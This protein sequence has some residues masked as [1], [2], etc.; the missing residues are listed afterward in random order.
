MGVKFKDYY[1]VLGVSRTASDEEI[2]KSFRKLARQHHPDVAKDKKRAEEKFKEINEAYEVLGDPAKRKKYDELG[3]NWKQGAEFRPP[4]G[5]EEMFQRGAS[6]GAGRGRGG[7]HEFQF[8][9]SGFSDFFE[10]FFA[11]RGRDGGRFRRQTDVDEEEDF[12]ERGAD[13]EGEILVTLEESLR[14]S[15][16]NVSVRTNQE[17]E[18]CGGTGGSR[19][20][21][22]PACGG[23]GQVAATETHKVKIPPGVMEGQR[24]RLAGRGGAG[25]GRGAAGDLYLRVRFAKHPE[26]D[27]ANGNLSYELDLAPWEAVLGTNISV[28]TLEG[29]VNIKIPAGTQNGHRLR[30]RGRGLGKE[31]ER[32]DLFVVARV[33]VPERI[34]ESERRLWE[35]LGRESTFE[36]R[37]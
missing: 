4:P 18:R 10:Q 20:Q 12:S 11:S 34:S 37:G 36:P 30:V 31:G 21:V 33:Q 9:G 13:M 2:K 6:A 32:G 17:C 14:G 35:Q 3:A 7:G 27:V 29:H 5:W 1:E 25:T 15:V 8:G 16:R 24:L 26:F 28:P 23:T 19:Q 22:C